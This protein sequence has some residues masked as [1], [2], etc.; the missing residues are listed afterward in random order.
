MGVVPAWIHSRLRF[1]LGVHAEDS[2]PGM[3]IQ[4]RYLNQ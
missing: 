2:G 3:K 4:L 1:V